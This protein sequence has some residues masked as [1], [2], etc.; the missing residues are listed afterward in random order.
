M[1]TVEVVVSLRQSPGNNQIATRVRTIRP[2]NGIS[3]KQGGSPGNVLP[4][5]GCHRFSQWREGACPLICDVMGRNSVIND[6][7]P[8]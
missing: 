2:P 8:P 1:A 6:T 7:V 3:F 5:R 4:D